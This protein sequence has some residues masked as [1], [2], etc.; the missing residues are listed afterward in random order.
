MAYGYPYPQTP[1]YFNTNY[2]PPQMPQAMSMPAAQMPVPSAPALI[3][4]PDELTARN[5]QF[6]MDG[7]PAYFVNANG[8][9]IYSKQLSMADG[10]VIFR[11]YKREAETAKADA[12]AYVTREELDAK[13][14]ELYQM[15]GAATAP[16]RSEDT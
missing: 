1:S 14:E 9:E 13:M 12:P 15:V 10:S 5:A 3:T 2:M 11:R 16:E 6:P 8:T 4:V 7:N